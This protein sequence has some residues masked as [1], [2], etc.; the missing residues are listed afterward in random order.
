MREKEGTKAGR[1]RAAAGWTLLAATGLMYAGIRVT[2]AGPGGLFRDCR[3]VPADP[4]SGRVAERE[5]GGHP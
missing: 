2:G 1:I 3:D 5:R 4:G